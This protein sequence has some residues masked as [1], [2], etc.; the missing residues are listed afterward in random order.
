MHHAAALAVTVAS[1]PK[2]GLAV[3]TPGSVGKK[4]QALVVAACARR[5]RE[6]ILNG[7]K[8]LCCKRSTELR[9]LK[10]KNGAG[11]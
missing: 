9:F 7:F 4:D 3:K 1:Q 6:A 8:L 10:W 5:W 11:L 2:P